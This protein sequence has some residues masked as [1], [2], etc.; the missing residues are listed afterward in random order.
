VI[1]KLAQ[2]PVFWFAGVLS[3]YCALLA[4]VLR[5]ERAGWNRTCMHSENTATLPASYF[6]Q[7]RTVENCDRECS[8]CS[9]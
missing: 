9:S 7:V 3:A 5:T 6:E 2:D 4:I 1:A 8:S